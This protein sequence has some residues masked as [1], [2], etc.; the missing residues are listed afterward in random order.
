[1]IRP[2][3]TSTRRPRPEP[4]HPALICI[5]P[6]CRL[7]ACTAA[8]RILDLARSCPGNSLATIDGPQPSNPQLPR[9]EQ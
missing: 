6:N 3:P 7:A 5:Y 1:M 2:G 4:E 9:V 8:G